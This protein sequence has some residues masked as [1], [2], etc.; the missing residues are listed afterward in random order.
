MTTFRLTATPRPP[1]PTP[2]PANPAKRR[3]HQ[4]RTIGLRLQ[5]HLRISDAPEDNNELFATFGLHRPRIRWQCQDG[6]GPCPWVSCRYHM[7]HEKTSSHHKTLDVRTGKQDPQISGA[8][9]PDE[10]DDS[11][12]WPEYLRAVSCVLDV[13][14]AYASL[15]ADQIAPLMGL[16]AQGVGAIERRA[17][18]KLKAHVSSLGSED[19][20]VGIDPDDD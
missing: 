2:K 3:K 15:T 18:A 5:R 6:P 9:D 10:S 8:A 12:G 13:T 19:P 16:T 7:A 14:D 20:V 11:D 1:P 4:R 17:L